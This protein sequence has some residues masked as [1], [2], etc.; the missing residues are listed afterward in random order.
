MAKPAIEMTAALRDN[1]ESERQERIA[2]LAFEF[3]LARAFRGGSPETDWFRAD[4]EVRS[5]KATLPRG[6]TTAGLF[7]V[8]PRGQ[9]SVV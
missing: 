7:L 5:K 4:R 1:V 2:A 8:Q 9:S 3:W 6:R